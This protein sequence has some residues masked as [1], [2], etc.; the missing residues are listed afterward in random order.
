MTPV[1]SEGE[2]MTRQTFREW[3]PGGYKLYNY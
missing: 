1:G 3:F 2:G